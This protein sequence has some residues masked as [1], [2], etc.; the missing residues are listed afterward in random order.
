[1]HR[2]LQLKKHVFPFHASKVLHTAGICVADTSG[3]L[4]QDL[5]GYTQSVLLS[6]QQNVLI[7]HGFLLNLPHKLN[8]NEINLTSLMHHLISDISIANKCEK[9]GC[10]SS[11]ITRSL[12]CLFLYFLFHVRSF[13][14]LFILTFIEIKLQSFQQAVIHVP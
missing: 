10:T 5:H 8:R 4:H 12:V 13:Y 9:L 1:M 3:D 14:F 2:S 6:H 11:P 7:L